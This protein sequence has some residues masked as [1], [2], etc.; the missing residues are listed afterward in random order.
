MCD[1]IPGTPQWE[2]ICEQCGMC[3]LLKYCDD[4]GN[5]FMTNVRCAALDKD[6]RKCACY[7]S[8]MNAR[9]NGCENCIALNGARVTYETL[10]NDYPVPS[11]CPYAQRFC[12]NSA[13]KKA[14]HR[15][16]I[17][18]E[19][20][21]SELEL[22]DENPLANHIIPGSKKYFKYNPHVNKIW[23]ENLKKLKKR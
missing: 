20:T 17:D 6:T 4:L 2:S 22:S 16:Y 19:K 9:D 1:I 14:S 12:K 21:I 18:W 5:I 7:A 13:V 23:H 15:P 3:C 8:D 10:N 11:F